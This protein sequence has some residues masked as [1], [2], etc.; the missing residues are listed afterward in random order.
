MRVLEGTES[1]NELIGYL[2]KE[3]EELKEAIRE[4]YTSARWYVSVLVLAILSNGGEL[5]VN[6]KLLDNF[7]NKGAVNFEVTV[8]E[9]GRSKITIKEEKNESIS[10][11]K[12]D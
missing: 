5:I 1:N 4:A 6:N 10:E 8:L 2:Q 12:T 3:N 7:A 9:D 11:N